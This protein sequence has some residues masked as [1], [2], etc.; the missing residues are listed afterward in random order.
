[1][2]IL[3][4]TSLRHNSYCLFEAVLTVKSWSFRRLSTSES[5]ARKKTSTATLST[6]NSFGVPL[7]LAFFDAVDTK[8]I[9]GVFEPLS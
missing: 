9:F 6:F 5:R 1:M 3:V 4:V 8:D 2:S 7:T